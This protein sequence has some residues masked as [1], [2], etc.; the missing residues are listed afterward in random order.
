MHS[1]FS[2]PI[3]R[4]V[5]LCLV[6]YASV[7][8][9]QTP[10]DDETHDFGLRIGTGILSGIDHAVLPLV[11]IGT[12][13]YFLS[14]DIRMVFGV[15]FI[16]P[17]SG[18]DAFSVAGLQYLGVEYNLPFLKNKAQI[19]IKTVKTYVKDASP[20]IKGNR[21]VAL[22]VGYKHPL[23]QHVEYYVQVGAIRS[24]IKEVTGDITIESYGVLFRSGLE[25]YF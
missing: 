12:D 5:L 16:Y 2:Y 1:I 3:K 11:D 18:T 19:G 13:F 10:Y 4:L 14:S 21:N 24:P 9:A 17:H 20:D 25:F 6:G 8:L 22:Y 7:V 15:S 23:R